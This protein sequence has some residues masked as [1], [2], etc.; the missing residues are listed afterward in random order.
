MKSAGPTSFGAQLKALREAAGYTQEELATIAGVS[1]YAVSALER[2]ERRRPQIDTVNAL[3]AALD[4]SGATRDRFLRIAHTPLDRSPLD[5]TPT[6]SMPLAPTSLLGRDDDVET[7]RRWLSEPAVRL[8]TLTGPGGVGK[9]RL[10]L[11]VARIIAAEG[12]V[13][14]CFVPLAAARDETVVASAIA[15]ALGLSNVPTPDLPRRAQMACAARATLLVLDNLEQVLVA[16]PLIADLLSTA[17]SLRLLTTSRASLRV[18]GERE[19]AVG[20]L[21]LDVDCGRGAPADQARSPA[22]QLFVER[23]RDV[24][25]D[26]TVTDGNR[27]TVAAICQRLDGLPLALELAAP[28]IKVLSPEDLLRRLAHDVL[29]STTSRRDLPARQQTMNATVAWSYQ[30]LDA[31]ERC[32]FRR[33]GALPGP[34]PI[35]AADA[36][37]AGRDGGATDMDEAIRATAGLIDKSL[38]VRTETA[39]VPSRALFNMLETVRAYAGHE[40]SGAGERDEAM[41]GLVR[42]CS[43]EAARAAEGL[44]GLSQVEWLD[45]VRE[46]LESYR[47]ALAWLIE[48]GSGVEA[49]HIAWSLHWFSVIRGNATEALRWYQQ[50]LN[51]RSLPPAAESRMLLAAAAMSYIK[52]ELDHARV[53][54]TRALSVARATGDDDAMMHVEFV[55]GHIEHATGHFAAARERFTRSIEGFRRAGQAWGIGHLLTA[56]A[57]VALATGEVEEGERLLD[58]AVHVL[59]QA[60]PWFLSLGVYVRA[61]LAVRRGEAD[62]AI[63]LVHDTLVAIRDIQDRFAFVYATAPLVCAAVLKGDHAWAARILGAR[64]VVTETTGATVVDRLGRDLLDAAHGEARARLTA[65]EWAAAYAAGRSMSIDGLLAD[66]DRVLSR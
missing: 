41:E 1:V 6:A 20:P 64:D 22:M 3:A 65:Q 43:T 32:A 55:F 53:G 15:E 35:E 11:E 21:P 28:W 37:L 12:R 17:A 42:Y 14:V 57:W 66:I 4:L 7:L 38:V 19:Y 33:F 51:L 24:K 2:G 5:D 10:A 46:N 44:V 52:G 26:F 25:P 13:R 50:I 9:T 58:E 59:R 40:L 49:A 23:V 27:A 16:V 18:R 56:L 29:D 61:L 8:V 47:A 48:R 34:F 31:E 39:A 60:G 63:A 62:I 30:L 54:L 36:V 45:R